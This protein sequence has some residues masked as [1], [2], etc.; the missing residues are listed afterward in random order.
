MTT[1]T[2]TPEV[3]KASPRNL[4][5]D[6]NVG[7]RV[8]VHVSIKE[9]DKERVQVFEGDVIAKKR[10]TYGSFTVRKISFGIGVERTFP[11]QTPKIEKVEVVNRGDV[12]RSKLYYLRNLSGKA[13]RLTTDTQK[14]DSN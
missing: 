3:T 2:T 1:E 9:G 12:T 11:L 5:D 13:A 4:A 10:G 6:F 8:R 7:N 14:S